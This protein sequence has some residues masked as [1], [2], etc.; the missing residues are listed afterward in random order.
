MREVLIDDLLHLVEPVVVDALRVEIAAHLAH[1][2]DGRRRIVV[3]IAAEHR[4]RALELALAALEA[5]NELVLH[6][7]ETCVA[8]RERQ[9]RGVHAVG[10]VGLVALLDVVRTPLTAEF[11]AAGKDV[12]AILR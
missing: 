1:E 11:M 3:E 5:V 9:R 4:V 2:I 7:G 8:A 6:L 10:R 12:V